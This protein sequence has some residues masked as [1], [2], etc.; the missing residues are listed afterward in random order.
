[1]TGKSRNGSGLSNIPRAK[2]RF[3]REAAGGAG[4][5]CLSRTCVFKNLLGQEINHAGGDKQNDGGQL[6]A[7]GV[8]PQMFS[9]PV[10][11]HLLRL[12]RKA[13]T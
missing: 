9:L 13:C 7:A 10:L 6:H 11:N 1:M 4:L 12:P 2:N 3:L 8:P 5:K